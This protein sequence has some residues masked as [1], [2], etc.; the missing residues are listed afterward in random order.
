MPTASGH[1]NLSWKLL[2]LIGTTAVRMWVL[3]AEPIAFQLLARS[4]C[5][6][7]VGRESGLGK[8]LLAK[9]LFQD[10]QFLFHSQRALNIGEGADVTASLP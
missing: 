9:S 7:T 6:V 3:Q 2:L 5:N 8:V 4:Q 1:L 10:E